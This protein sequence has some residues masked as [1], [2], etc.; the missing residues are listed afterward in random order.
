MTILGA[1]QTFLSR[2]LAIN[3]YC[4]SE[5][6]FLLTFF[7][8]FPL[9]FFSLFLPSSTYLLHYHQLGAQAVGKIKFV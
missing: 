8:L 4:V 3:E 5:F 7:L 6:L 1:H 2:E 9:P